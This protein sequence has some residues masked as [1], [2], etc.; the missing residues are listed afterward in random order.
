MMWLRQSYD[1]ALHAAGQRYARLFLYF[2][3]FFESIIIPIPTDPLLAACTHA[4]PSLWKQIALLCA[5]SSVAGGAVGWYLGAFSADYVM[6][7]VEWLPHAVMNEEKFAAV[8]TA[9]Q[10]VGL[11]L[12]LIGAFT[13]LPFK[14]IAISSGLFAYP[15]LPFLLIAT[16][17]RIGRFMLVGAMVRYHKNS[18]LLMALI[19]LAL[20][21]VL[22]A[23][24]MT[25]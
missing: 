3:S 6:R 9:F 10:K 1:R 7:L 16:I 24:W 12:V 22:L 8:A 17:G 13:P 2:F 18:R 14:V 25:I 15:L 21:L 20:V 23:Y 11:I 4:K 5:L 19:T